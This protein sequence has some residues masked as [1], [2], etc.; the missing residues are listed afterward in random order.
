M[1]LLS[2]K[3]N[4]QV[5]TEPLTWWEYDFTHGPFSLLKMKIEVEVFD[6]STDWSRSG[7]R[8]FDIFLEVADMM[9]I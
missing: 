5:A 8:L 7:G 2:R 1:V 4:R 9:S 3:Q 6:K